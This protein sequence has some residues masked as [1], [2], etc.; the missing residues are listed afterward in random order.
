MNVHGMNHFTILTDNIEVTRKFYKTV[1]GLREGY[2]PDFG[3]PGIW[4]YVDDHPLLHVMSQ[5]SLPKPPAGVIDHMAFSAKNL[6]GTVKRLR[7]L[8]IEHELTHQVGTRLWQI[9]FHDPHG[10][11]IELDFAPDE[12]PPADQAKPRKANGGRGKNG[13]GGKAKAATGSRPRKR[14]SP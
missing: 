8:G 5:K 13:P 4:F 14:A 9:F 2:R 12:T 1:L 11:K 3:F 6:A 10:A 7:K